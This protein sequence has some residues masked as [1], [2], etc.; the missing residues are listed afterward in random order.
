M[1]KRLDNFF[2]FIGF[3]FIVFGII[4]VLD[5]FIRGNFM[6]VLWFS[7]IALILIGFGLYKKNT[8]LIITQLNIVIIPFIVWNIDFFYVLLFNSRLLGI[9]DYFFNGSGSALRYIT[10]QHVVIIPVSLLAI[11]LWKVQKKDLWKF[12]L[13]Q[14]IIFFGVIRTFTSAKANINLA[15]SP[16]PFLAEYISSEIYPF[17]W[18]L[19]YFIMIFIVNFLLVELGDGRI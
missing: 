2:G 16:I 3:V 15:F 10:L 8:S 14:V 17:F 11:Y 1:G 7:Y 9:T 19:F 18:I 5:S 12:S 4:A 6:Q 13:M